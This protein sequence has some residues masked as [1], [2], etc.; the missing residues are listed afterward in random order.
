MSCDVG[1][2]CASDLALLCRRLGA[3]VPIQPLAWELPYAA[4][5]A[6]KGQKKKEKKK[7][8]DFHYLP[9]L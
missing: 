5:V 4:H 9:G 2:E 6:I 3:A 7:K 8:K 1:H